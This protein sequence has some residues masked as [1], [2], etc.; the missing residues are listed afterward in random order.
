MGNKI[1][2][3]VKDE[4][5]SKSTLTIKQQRFVEEYCKHF[6]ASKAAVD[7]GYSI[8]TA[9]AIGCE[10]LIKPYIKEAIELRVNALTMSANEA[11]VRL[12]DFA[13]GSFKPFLKITENG[14]VQNLTLDLY[15]DDAQR[16]LH[17]IKKIKQTKKF[18]GEGLMDIVTE[19]ELHDAK[20]AT[21]KVLQLHGKLIE[22]KQI[23]HTSNGEPMSATQIIFTKGDA[24]SGS[25]E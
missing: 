13:R 16:S 14:D 18:F 7:A 10:N 2:K 4:D 11:L 15:S 6:N 1:I 22:K 24:G 25:S 9:A 8:Y 19:I 17:L 23:D 3:P 5:E 20:D 21:V 12:T